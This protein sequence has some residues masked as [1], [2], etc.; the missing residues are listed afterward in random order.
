MLNEFSQEKLLVWFKKF[1]KAKSFFIFNLG[2]DAISQT[3]N[4]INDDGKPAKDLL[5]ELNRL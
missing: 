5:E 4:I 3:R 1:T 2:L